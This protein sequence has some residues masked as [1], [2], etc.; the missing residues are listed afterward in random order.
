MKREQRVLCVV[1]A[2]CDEAAAVAVPADDDGVLRSSLEALVEP[3]GGRLELTA[4]G[5]ACSPV[6]LRGS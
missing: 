5:T 4:P 1:L 3:L 6:K 2:A